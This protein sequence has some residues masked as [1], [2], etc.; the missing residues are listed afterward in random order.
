MVPTDWDASPSS[1]DCVRKAR[2]RRFAHEGDVAERMFGDPWIDDA[3]LELGSGFGRHGDRPPNLAQLIDEAAGHRDGFRLECAKGASARTFAEKL[4][5]LA[6]EGPRVDE[7][8]HR[9]HP[10]AR[11]SHFRDSADSPEQGVATDRFIG[12]SLLNRT[13]REF[14]FRG[15]RDRV[16]VQARAQGFHAIIGSDLGPGLDA[17]LLRALEDAGAGHK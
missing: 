16:L 2:H 7:A 13:G 17:G 9:L 8:A 10:K 5:H 3:V 6:G 1:L 15:E 12:R 11:L 14:D 4:I